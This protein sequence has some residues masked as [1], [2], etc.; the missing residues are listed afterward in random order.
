[1][2]HCGCINKEADLL[3]GFHKLCGAKVGKLLCLSGVD[4]M[5]WL[6]APHLES[7]LKSLL[8]LDVAV[9]DSSDLEDDEDP[10]PLRWCCW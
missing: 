9:Y 6:H 8:I 3:Q 7:F 10:S 1:M 4:R 2:A 5:T